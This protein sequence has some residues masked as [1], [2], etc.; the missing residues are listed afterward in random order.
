QFS[1]APDKLYGTG[2]TRLRLFA[3][4]AGY[5]PAFLNFVSYTRTTPGTFTY[6]PF[7]AGALPSGI[8]IIKCTAFQV[9]DMSSKSSISEFKLTTYIRPNAGSSCTGT[10]SSSLTNNTYDT[11]KVTAFRGGSYTN[12]CVEVNLE[13]EHVTTQ[14]LTILVACYYAGVNDD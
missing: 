6:N 9:E 4:G 8:A 14:G 5:D 10:P 1:I 7:G 13:W 12:K 2:R 3:S 11:K